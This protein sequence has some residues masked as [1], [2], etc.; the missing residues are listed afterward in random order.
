MKNKIFGRKVGSKDDMVLLIEANGVS[1]GGK[2]VDPGVI[3]DI[4]VASARRTAQI[5]RDKTIAPPYPRPSFPTPLK[6]HGCKLRKLTSHLDQLIKA[7]HSCS[8]VRWRD[9]NS[10]STLVLHCVEKAVPT[11]DV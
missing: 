9:K 5:L 11:R 6:Q 10:R 1:T 7:S 4:A 3:N 8:R 2:K